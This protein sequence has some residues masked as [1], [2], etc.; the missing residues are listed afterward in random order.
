LTAAPLELYESRP[1]RWPR[2]S[3]P[4][5]VAVYAGQG[6]DRAASGEISF[7]LRNGGMSPIVLGEA[8]LRSGHFLGASA[9]V[10]GDGSAREIV[11]GWDPAVPTRTT[12]WEAAEPRR[13]IG[14]EGL[15]AI[16]RFVR[17]GGRVVTIGRSAGLVAPALVD[18]ALPAVRPGIGEVQVEIAQAA[19]SFFAGVPAVANH[20]RAFIYAPPF[21]TEGGYLFKARS[22]GEVL[23]WYAGADDRPA[24]QSFADTAP[25]ARSAGN[26]AIVAATVGKG[27]VVL[28]GFSP[29]FRA[30]W[31]STF[32]LL[33]NAV[34]VK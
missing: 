24:E 1:A 14:R 29:V 2:S 19:R 17:E 27:R 20:A 11:D 34:A 26:A 6:I 32:P 21:G 16:A 5:T 4:A 28:F 12:P 33:F 22:P 3:S 30:Q 13:G 15:D 7:V 31:R 25:L 18:V 23:A 9:V 8:D 10:F